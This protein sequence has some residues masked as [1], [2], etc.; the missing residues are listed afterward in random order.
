M[1]ADAPKQRKRRYGNNLR[2]AKRPKAHATTLDVLQVIY[3]QELIRSTQID[4][5][6]DRPRDGIRRTLKMLHDKGMVSKVGDKPD[7]LITE[8]NYYAPDVYYISEAGIKFLFDY[9]EPD[10]YV[11]TYR[12]RGDHRIEYQH[13]LGIAETIS[14]IRAGAKGSPC[15][16]IS[17]GELER[18]AG[19][20]DGLP[21]KFPASA[22]CEIDGRWREW[23]GE[24]E[25]DGLFAIEYPDGARSYIALEY[26]REGKIRPK[27]LLGVS[28]MRRK[29]LAYVNAQ[30]NRAYAPF[31][32]KYVRV[33]F[34][35]SKVS[36]FNESL[37]L[38]KEMYPDGN[39][40]FLFTHQPEYRQTEHGFINA[41]RPNPELFITPLFRTGLAPIPLYDPEK[42]PT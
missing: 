19:K 17:Q 2:L 22:S 27:K 25:P 13:K 33:L 32:M 4:Q 28:S 40:M 42:D 1:E 34:V 30:Q 10:L 31:S 26:Q 21:V 16:F 9:R 29:M 35:F 3:E 39:P 20:D 18:E 24:L 41:P 36:A 12:P 7:D 8:I 6:V 11:N 37:A 23:K 5:L 14:N 15:R 38:A